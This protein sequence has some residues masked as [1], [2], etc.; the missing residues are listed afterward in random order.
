MYVV[1]GSSF[2][3]L[4]LLHYYFGCGRYACKAY[5]FM[6]LV[7]TALRLFGLRISQLVGRRL[8]L[9]RFFRLLKGPCFMVDA[10]PQFASY[11][12]DVMPRGTQKFR[13]P[14]VKQSNVYKCVYPPTPFCAGGSMFTLPHSLAARSKAL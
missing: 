1:Q 13:K 14:L 12:L 9:F 7:Y 10:L 11:C 5:Y 3:F 8:G 2:V 4:A 6:A